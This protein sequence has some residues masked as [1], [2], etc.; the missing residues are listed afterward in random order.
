MMQHE[1]RGHSLFTF[2]VSVGCLAAQRFFLYLWSLIDVPDHVPQFFFWILCGFQY[3]QVFYF[4]EGLLNHIF[5]Y[6]FMSFANLLFLSFFSL[7]LLSYSYI[8]ISLFFSHFSCH[9]PFFSAYV[10]RS[11]M[12]SCVAFNYDFISK[13]A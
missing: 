4:W 12:F 13:I 9:Y 1:S 3:I 2:F 11:V 8:F 7:I 6:T 10:L 5:T